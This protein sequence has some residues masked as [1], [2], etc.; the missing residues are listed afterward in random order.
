[1]RGL[2]SSMSS[3]TETWL[4]LI[5]SFPISLASS[6]GMYLYSLGGTSVRKAYYQHGG[7]TICKW[8]WRQRVHA[9]PC[10]GRVPHCTK[11]GVFDVS[12]V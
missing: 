2:N 6:S 9:F 3:I 8:I 1:M 5:R 10:T 7:S 4:S 12:R 11:F